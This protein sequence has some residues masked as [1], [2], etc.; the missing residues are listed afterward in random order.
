MLPSGAVVWHVKQSRLLRYGCSVF[1]EH[2]GQLLAEQQS[3][4]MLSQCYRS[5]RELMAAADKAAVAAA[6]AAAQ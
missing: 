2:A 3:S 1:E 6:A 5:A 4:R